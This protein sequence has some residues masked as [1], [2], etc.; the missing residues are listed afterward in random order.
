[1]DG[2]VARAER[3]VAAPAEE[4]WGLLTAEASRVYFGAQ[5]ESDWQVGSPVVWR[6]EWEGKPFEDRGRVV[7][8]DPPSR[9]VITHY[10]PLSGEE[11]RPENYHRMEY[12]LTEVGGGTHVVLEQDGNPTQDAADHAAANWQKMLDGLADIAEQG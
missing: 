3:D 2:Y 11:D 4:I 12:L 6:G 1:M 5:V 8:A 10:S 9:L 7:E